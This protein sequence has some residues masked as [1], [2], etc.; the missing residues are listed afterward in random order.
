MSTF[1]MAVRDSATMLRRDA[2]HSQRNIATTVTGLL[3]PIIM[4]TLFNYVFGGAIGAGL[5]AAHGGSY[6]NFLLP[7]I[8]IMTVGSGCETTALNLCMDMSEGVITRFRTMAI[9]RSSVLTGQVVGSLIRTMVSVV[10]VLGVGLLMGFRTSASPVAWIEVFG[11][12]ALFTL[13]ISWMGV[14]F[15]LIGKTPSG[16]NSLALLFTLLAFTSSAFVPLDSMAPGVRWFA[17]YQPFTPVI[18]TVR[19]L[20]MG[21]PVGN[22]VILL[23]LVWCVVFILAG[24]L[25]ARAVYNR[26]PVR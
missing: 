3:V 7:G 4:L 17:Q 16:A 21:T 2:R 18:D 23:A 20:L 26:D 9:A 13:G 11:V 14:L 24:Y 19:G 22:N 12:T 25:G 8:L 10:F 1:S 15:G 6:V 5:G